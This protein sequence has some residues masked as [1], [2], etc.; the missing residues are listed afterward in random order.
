MFVADRMIAI[1]D[2]ENSIVSYDMIEKLDKMLTEY[3]VDHAFTLYDSEHQDTDVA[4]NLI[5]KEEDE[6]TVELILM[7][8]AKTKRHYTDDKIK[9]MMRRAAE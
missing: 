4:F 3:G 8:W 9:E 2:R 7:L 5:Y 6:I 1:H